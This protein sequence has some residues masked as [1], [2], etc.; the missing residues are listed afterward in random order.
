MNAYALH[1]EFGSVP[2]L[3]RMYLTARYIVDNHVIGRRSSGPSVTSA[4]EACTTCRYEPNCRAWLFQIIADALASGYRRY[5]TS[6]PRRTKVKPGADR[7]EESPCA[8][9][10]SVTQDAIPPP[11]MSES[12]LK[13]AVRALP[14]TCRTMVALSLLNGFSHREIA[15][16][17]G[18]YLE[19]VIPRLHQARDMISQNYSTLWRANSILAHCQQYQGAEV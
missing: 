18:V 13:A 3:E 2:E 5:V 16:L 12:E 1:N 19:S 9:L 6:V 11:I 8:G 4:T 14:Q 10:S 17:T 7:S 15:D